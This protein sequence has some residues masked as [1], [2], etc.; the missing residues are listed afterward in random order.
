MIGISQV[1]GA[2]FSCGGVGVL[3]EIPAPSVGLS[4]ASFPIAIPP[5]NEHD[6]SLPI[7]IASIEHAESLPIATE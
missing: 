6:V 4:V 5:L 1:A 7:A 2:V 3:I